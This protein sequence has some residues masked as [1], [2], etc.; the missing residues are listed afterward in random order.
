VLPALIGRDQPA[1]LLESEIQRTLDSHG[2]LVLVAGEAGIGKTTLISQMMTKARDNGALVLSATCWDH[3]GAPGYWPWVQVL[4]AIR[5]EFGPDGW[6]EVSSA[7]GDGLTFLLGDFTEPPS[8]LGDDAE[9]WLCDALTTLLATVARDRPVIVALDDLHWADAPSLR[10]V[11]FVMRHTWFERIL[12]VGTYRDVEV[13]SE[14]PLAG[15]LRSLESKATTMTLAGLDRPAVGDLI[16]R[17]T[18]QEPDRDV[19]TEIHRRTGGNPLFVEQLADLWQGH[20]QTDVVPLG[21]RD[22]VHRRLELLPARLRELLSQAAVLG[23]EF[24]RRA[25]A[26]L[27]GMPVAEVHEM[28]HHATLNR[29]VSPAES[30]TFVFTH[31][32]VRD[33]L[34]TGLSEDER[35]LRHASALRVLVDTHAEPARLAYHA[36]LAVPD[37]TADEA[38]KHL[39]AAGHEAACRQVADEAASH[40]RRAMKLVP[41]DQQH[42]RA[43]IAAR[44]ND[45]L[46]KSRR[47]DEPGEQRPDPDPGGGDA[48]E[49]GE[50]RF[51]G[52]VWTLTF[53]E[54]TVHVPDAKGL[55]DLHALLGQ[56]GTDI[57]A[58]TLLTADA[59][60]E[61]EA[62][63]SL[64]GDAVLDETAKAQYKRRL[65]ELDDEI[66]RAVNFDDHDRAAALDREREALLDEL[67]RAAGL[68]GPDR[69]HAAADLRKRPTD[70]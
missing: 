26:T 37:V 23:P 61:A 43:L 70:N 55:H 24:N 57:P 32:L 31:E 20:G 7:A 16:A 38:V 14:H 9:F 51:D 66:D 39:L 69:P 46:Q 5:R 27:A 4:R 52:S 67:R 50:F 11:D 28:L 30:G 35:R 25:V 21:I 56:P 12:L 3:E 22:V 1:E 2:G 19:V 49:F 68:G 10:A 58:A 45:P 41:A 29:L 33:I 6:E 63:R 65:D 48:A 60:A 53:A 17:V 15:L 34:Y 47:F 18:G 13:E 44:V 42:R 62:A 40:F 36:Y 8:D 59:P 54:R 64:G